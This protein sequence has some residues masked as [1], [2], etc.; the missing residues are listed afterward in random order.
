M[1][2]LRAHGRKLAELCRQLSRPGNGA[3]L[4]PALESDMQQELL[5]M[6]HTPALR[7]PDW[8]QSAPL[9]SSP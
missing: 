1:R 7:R 4:I 8:K 9:C 2:R 5:I 3:T 6:Q